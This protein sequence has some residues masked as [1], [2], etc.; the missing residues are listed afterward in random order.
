[1]R[2]NEDKSEDGKISLNVTISNIDQALK[3]KELS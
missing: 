2:I 1:M 3:L